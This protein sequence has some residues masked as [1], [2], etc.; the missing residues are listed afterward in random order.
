LV[1]GILVVCIINKSGAIRF[2]VAILLP[3]LSFRKDYSL[4]WLFWIY[5]IL[6]LLWVLS[7]H[8][9]SPISL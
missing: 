8:L 3:E 5:N 6:N 1:H 2:F 9:R 7:E 4:A